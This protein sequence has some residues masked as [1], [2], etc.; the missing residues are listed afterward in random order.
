MVEIDERYCPCCGKF[1]ST[2]RGARSH[3]RTAQSCASYRMGKNR[4][5][6]VLLEPEAG[7]LTVEENTEE[8]DEMLPSEVMEGIDDLF[9]FIPGHGNPQAPEA[10]P[11]QGP[12]SR[13]II[14]DT[15]LDRAEDSR[16][17]D[18]DMT[19]GR[20]IRMNPH[21]HTKW[22]RLFGHTDG[23]IEMAEPGDEI[24]EYAP[25]ASEMDWKIANWVVK[26]GPGHNAFDRLLE[27]PGV[28][29]L[30]IRLL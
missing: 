30:L 22:K 5:V 19:A 26:D 16:V 9:H 27:I 1:F 18:V 23:D 13:H 25:F 15:H 14:E 6:P 17:E 21:L 28:R 20:V 12:R 8:M 11:S 4:E 2:V 7:E 29:V 3:L 24:N 10:G